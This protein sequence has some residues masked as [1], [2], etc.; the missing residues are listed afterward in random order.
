MRRWL[1][2]VLLAAGMG[3][4]IV[5]PH[6][7][8][9]GTK[10]AAEPVEYLALAGEAPARIELRVE[11]DGR[12]VQ[13][14]WDESFARLLAY[15]DRNGDG[16]LDRPEAARLPSP[17]A[18]RQLLWGQLTLA[19]TDPPAWDSLDADRDGKVIG[20]ELAAF[21]R[22]AG[23]G[24]A[25]TGVGKPPAGDKLTDALLTAFDVNKDGR[26]DE[27]EWKSAPEALRKLDRN[28]DELI[29]PG[30]LVAGVAYPGAS[31]SRLLAIPPA[32]ARPDPLTDSLPLVVLPPRSEGEAWA[33]AVVERAGAATAPVTREAL[34]GARVGQPAASWTA[35]LGTRKGGASPVEMAGGKAPPGERLT[36][37]RGDVRLVLRADD[38]R[39]GEALAA[40]RK[41]ILGAFQESD[42]SGT[43]V[44]GAKELAGAKAGQLRLLVA[45]ADRDA[46]GGLSRAE[47]T[48]WL[49]LQEQLAKGHALVT[50]L[51]HGRGL[52][53]LLD[54]DHDGSL[55]LRELR[56]ALDRVTAAGCRT[57]R[58]I[59]RERLP[60]QLVAC[61]SQGHPRSAL[62]KPARPGPTWFVA[63]DRNGDGDVS[64]R[65]FT[66]PA[67]VFSRLDLDGDGL[68]SPEEA[69]RAGGKN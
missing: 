6:G 24:N 53:E 7:L 39:F 49:D 64:R 60:R 55:S 47:V 10:P 40:A 38:G 21:Y 56:G 57:E 67:D 37:S 23:L 50:V 69:V 11:I 61:V 66:G 19:A 44:L 3:V 34:L 20:A 48:A 22:R 41:S 45:L 32:G 27:G 36:L 12:P 4:V 54:A 43:G 8:G 1:P 17:F 63:M 29:G 2:P 65:E 33:A 51:D 52:F 31:A 59:D 25:L 9:G 13:E 42:S 28:D 68:L 5:A 46:D 58:G 30:E 14:H 18:V 15:F 62:G 35:R 16:A 26:V